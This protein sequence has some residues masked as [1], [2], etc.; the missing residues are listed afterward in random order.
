MQSLTKLWFALP[1][2]RLIFGKDRSSCESLDLSHI[3]CNMDNVVIACSNMNDIALAHH[4]MD[5]VAD[6]F[7]NDGV[8]N[9]KQPARRGS[10]S[11]S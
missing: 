5:H 2:G 3:A 11:S 10:T 8:D 6:T 7:S 9:T 1:V 4:N